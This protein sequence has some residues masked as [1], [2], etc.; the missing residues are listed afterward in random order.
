MD[1]EV[2]EVYTSTH[3]HWCG[4]C[5]EVIPAGVPYVYDF[6]TYNTPGGVKKYKNFPAHIGCKEKKYEADSK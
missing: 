1:K 3:E 2:A 4:I 5:N 6:E